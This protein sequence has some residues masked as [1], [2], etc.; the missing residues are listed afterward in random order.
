MRRWVSDDGLSAPALSAY[1]AAPGGVIYHFPSLYDSLLGTGCVP[2]GLG[3]P[4]AQF[5]CLPHPLNATYPQAAYPQGPVTV[6]CLSNTCESDACQLSVYLAA[7]IKYVHTSD[8]R[9]F[10][11]RDVSSEL[12]LLSE[13]GC[14]PWSPPPVPPNT[15]AYVADTPVD[16]SIFAEV[17]VIAE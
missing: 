13:S 7:D 16:V 2:R 11:A 15:R 4:P 17:R 8:G 6:G 12:Y 10:H 5:R 9:V 14:E 3:P 1:Q